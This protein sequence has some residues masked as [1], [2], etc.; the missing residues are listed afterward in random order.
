MGQTQA[1]KVVI[2]DKF[3]LRIGKWIEPRKMVVALH[4]NWIWLRL[5]ST[6]I[7]YILLYIRYLQTFLRDSLLYILFLSNNVL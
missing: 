7:L 3:I 1:Q 6:V 5:S 4:S 2:Q